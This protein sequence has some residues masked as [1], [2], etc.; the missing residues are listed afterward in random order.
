MEV[1]TVK[2]QKAKVSR[3]LKRIGMNEE[4]K[5]TEYSEFMHFDSSN[6]IGVKLKSYYNSVKDEGIPDRL[7]NLLDKLKH[8]EALSIDARHE[9][10]RR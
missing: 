2:L 7:L 8:Q 5:N 3:T 1:A 10:G 9:K 6:A 4:N